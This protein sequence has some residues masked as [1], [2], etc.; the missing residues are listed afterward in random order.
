MNYRSTDASISCCSWV[1]AK[2]TNTHAIAGIEELEPT[3]ISGIRTYLPGA[4]IQVY[5]TEYVWLAYLPSD[6]NAR[7]H[8]HTRP[9]QEHV[10]MATTNVISALINIDQVRAAP[11]I[12]PPRECTRT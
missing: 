11:R 6:S 4:T 7:T 9:T 8:A 3:G 10:D 12:N 1:C 5:V 2:L